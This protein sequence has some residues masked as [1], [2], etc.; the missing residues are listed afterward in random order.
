[1]ARRRNTR[2][3]PDTSQMS[4]PKVGQFGPRVKQVQAELGLPVTGIWNHS[5]QE[6]VEAPKE[7]S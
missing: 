7:D 1:M 6:A 2:S 3:T 5:D 4:L